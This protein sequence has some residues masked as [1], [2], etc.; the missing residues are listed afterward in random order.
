MRLLRW[1]VVVVSL[2]AVL[3][4]S[5]AT[6]Y[7]ND[8]STNGDIYCST[9]GVDAVGRG[10]NAATPAFSL[11]YLFGTYDIE[12]GET[13][14]IDTG[15][16][17]NYY[18]T[19]TSADGGSG[20]TY[21]DFRG[22]TNRTIGTVMVP[23]SGSPSVITLQDADYCRFADMT[24]QGGLYGVELTSGSDFNEF[25]RVRFLYNVYGV[26]GVSGSGN[27]FENCMA[28]F[29]SGAGVDG[30]GPGGTAG[31]GNLWKNGVSYGNTYGFY[32]NGLSV[33][34]SVIV[35]GVAFGVQ[36]R[37]DYNVFWDTLL[38]PE[39]LVLSELQAATA[40]FGHSTVAD[41][42]FAN[43]TGLDF[44][45]WSRTGR[46][47]PSSGTYVITDTNYSPVIDIGYPSSIYTNEPSPFNGARVN[48]GLYGNTR[49]AS[50]SRTNTWLQVLSYN[51][52]D[53]FLVTGRLWW[54]YG[55]TSSTVSVKLE[56]AYE[57]NLS[58]WLSIVTN[59]PITNQ[60]YQWT[61]HVI[62]G[63]GRW[64]VVLNAD[65]NVRDMS[66]AP[67]S[68]KTSVTHRLVFYVNDTS[69]VN[70]AYCGSIGSFTNHGLTR[71]QPLP[72]LQAVLDAYHISPNDL[73][74][75]DTGTYRL[76][77]AITPS[78]SDQGLPGCPVT[79]RGSTN[80]VA[81]GSI[82]SPTNSSNMR[83]LTV[84][85]VDYWRMENVVLQNA[86]YGVALLN[87]ANSNE[88]IGVWFKDNY[89]GVRG[90]SGYGNHFEN[91]V[92]INN[93]FG[94]VDGFGPGGT[95]GSGNTWK[96]GVSYGNTYAFYVTGM[97]I[98]NSVMV[99]GT[100]FGVSAPGDYNLLWNTTP[101]PGYNNI[102]ALQKDVGSQAH[103]TVADPQFADA[104]NL[105]FH[106]RS[107]AGR[108]DPS[109]GTFVTTD[110][111][112]SPAVD[113]GDPMASYANELPPD[114]A[115][116]NA[117]AF[118][119]T[120]EASKGRT[121]A[122]LQVLN[123]VDGGT[124]NVP[125]D[126]VYWNAGQMAASTTVRIEYS[127]DGG[128]NWDIVATNI[129]ASQGS[130]VWTNTSYG[131]TRSARWRVVCETNTMLF[132]STTQTNFIL[133]N[134]P[135]LYYVNDSS[136]DGDIYCSG[137]GNDFN[138]GTSS[139]GP[140]A[141]LKAL[142]SAHEVQPGDIIYMD[143]GIYYYNE[144]QPIGVLDQGD[145]NSP[146]II[147]GSTNVVAGGTVI[148][149]QN[150]GVGLDITASYLEV[151]DISVTNANIGVQVNNGVSN[152][153]VRVRAERNSTGFLLQNSVGTVFER[154]VAAVNSGD[155]LSLVDSDVSVTHSILWKN[156]GAGI[157]ASG[158]RA[159]ITNSIVVVSGNTAYG[160]HATTSTNIV[161]NHN[162]LYAE[163]HGVVGFIASVGRNQDSLAAWT[164]DTG[165]ER[166]SLSVDPL[167][168]DPENGDFHLKTETS[169]GRYQPGVGWVLDAVTSVLIDS[170]DPQSSWT[171]EPSYN[172]RRVNIGLF[173]NTEE[174][175][176]GRSAGWLHAASLEG[177][178]WVKGTATLHW[179]AGGGATSHAVRV[180]YSPDG[181]ATW[182]VLTNSIAA[183]LESFS[184]DTTK[185]N[186]TPAGL[187]KV[188]STN[189]AGVFDQ[190]TNFFSVR[191][192][193]LVLYVN[194]GSVV[195]DAFSAGVG[196]VA[197]WVASSNRPLNSLQTALT[198][199]DLEPGD[200]IYVDTGAYTNS[201]VSTVSRRDSGSSNAAVQII[202]STNRPGTGTILYAG[203][204]NA[205]Y[206]GLTA[207]YANWLAISNLTLRG[208]FGGM[209]LDNANNLSMGHIW[210][211]ANT[212][213][214]VEMLNV[215]N[216][217]LARCV[218]TG[219][220]GRGMFIQGAAG[221][222]VVHSVIWSN[223]SDAIYHSGGSLAVTNSILHASGVGRYILVGVSNALVRSDY[224]DMVAGNSAYV[225][226]DGGVISKTLSRWQERTSNDVHSLS[227]DPRFSSPLSD[228]HL[229]SLA[230]RYNPATG[231]FVATDTDF[232]YLL[233]AG[234]PTW[235]IGSESGANGGRVNIG[236]F[237]GSAEASRS[238]AA[239]WFVALTY[240]DGGIARGTNN[241]RWVVGGSATDDLVYVDYS[242]DGGATWS[243]VATNV[244]AN[245]GFI[246]WDTTAY[247]SSTRG[248]WR[249]TSQSDGSIV[250]QTDAL[251]SLN[252]EPLAY[253]VNDASTNG[254]VYCSRAGSSTN[255]GLSED[256][257]IDSV[258]AVL[259]RYDL[260]PG[261]R[262]LVDTGV[263][264]LTNAITVGNSIQG[265]FTNRIAIQ[266]STNMTDGGSVLDG[267]S[268]LA[269]GIYANGAGNVEFRHLQ[270]RHAGVGLKLVNVTNCW[271]EWVNTI[272]GAVGFEAEVS[273]NIYFTH[274]SARYA[275]TSGLYVASS[276]NV[277]WG[278]GVFWSNVYGVSMAHLA[279]LQGASVGELFVSNTIVGAFGAGRYAYRVDSGSLRADYNNLF[280]RGGAHVGLRSAYPYSLVHSDLSSWTLA[281]TQ[282]V[283]SLSHDPRFQDP[284]AGD[285]HLRSTAG[286]FDPAVRDFVTNNTDS[287]VLIDA[288]DPQAVISREPVPHGGRINIGL[289]GDSVE[290][291]KTPTN[292]MLAVVIP[293]DGGVVRG[294]NYSVKWFARGGATGHTVRLR[295]SPDEGVSWQTLVT[296]L[297][298]TNLQ[299]T[300]N[301]T[302]S[303]SSLFG[304]L[305]IQSEMD[306][307]VQDDSDVYFMLRNTNFNFYV[308]D[309]N[310][311]GDVYSDG[312]GIATNT[313]LRRENP[314]DSVQGI[315][316]TWDL[317]A[318]DVVYVDTGIYTGSLGR[319]EIGQ[320]DGG[321]VATS[322]TVVIYG[323]TN[324][325]H[326]GSVLDAAG[327]GYGLQL[328]QVSAVELRNLKVQNV[329]T[330]AVQFTEAYGCVAEWLS[331]SNVPTAF[332]LRLSD[333]TRF[334]HCTV[335][336]ASA[337]GL[338]NISASNTLWDSGVLWS[339]RIGVSLVS[340]GAYQTVVG[341]VFVSNSVIASF[342]S[343]S[344]VYSLGGGTL[345]ADYN[346]LY[347]SGGAYV[348]ERVA[349]PFSLI[350]DSV[351]RWSRA[352]KQ[353]MHGLSHEPGFVN[354]GAGDFHPLSTTGRYS[355][356]AGTHVST[357]AVS[358]LLI[359]AGAP[360]AVFG[361]EPVPNGSRR[362][363]GLYGNT[364]EASMSPT[365]SRLTVL[366]LNDGGIADGT[367]FILRW[368]ASGLATGHTVQVKYSPDAGVTW[369][370]LA[371][372]LASD[373]SYPWNTL[374]QTS[375]L[376]G[377]WMVVS[378][379]ETNV[380][381]RNDVFFAVR[382]NPISFYVNDASRSGD[383]YCASIGNSTNSGL[384]PEQP[385]E[386]VQAVL[387][388][389]DLEPEDILYVDTGVY[390]TF[391]DIV[392]NQFDAGDSNTEYVV[393]QGS[394]N[395]ME[396]G[397]VI[398]RRGGAAA[399]VISQAHRI[400]LRNLTIRNALAGV[401][402]SKSLDPCVEWVTVEGGNTGFGLSD[403]RGARFNHCLV[404]DA[405]SGLHS[406]SADVV[407]ENGILWS[408]TYGIYVSAGDVTLQDSVI[409]AYGTNSYALYRG[410]SASIASDYN[411]LFLQEGARAAYSPGV[412]FALVYHN[413][414]RW[415]RDSG[416]DRHSMNCDPLFADAAAGDFH[417]QSSTG[418]Y[419]VSSG[420][421]TNDLVTSPL[422]DAGTPAPAVFTNETSPNGG[423]RNIGLY[424]NSPQAS[425]TPT[426][427]VLRTLSLD[428]GGRAEGTFALNWLARGAV[429]SDTVRL[430]YSPDAG[431]TWLV[432]VTNVDAD[433]GFYVWDARS[434]PSSVRG[435]WS[436][437]AEGETNIY[438]QTDSLFALRNSPLSF[439]VNDGATGGD[440]YSVGSGSH[441][442]SGAVSNQ[443]LDSVVTLLRNWDLEPG[444]SVYIDT[445]NYLLTEDIVVD[446]FDAW[447]ST[448]TLLLRSSPETNRVMFVGSTNE[449]LGGTVFVKFGG[450]YVF[451]IYEAPGVALRN[452]TIRGADIGVNVYYSEQCRADWVRAENC[453]RGFDVSL[454]DSMVMEHCVAR[455]CADRGLSV[456][457]SRDV[458]WLSG[459]LWSNRIGVHQEALANSSHDLTVKNS[460]L[461]SFG[462]NAT[463][464]FIVSG[465][466]VSDYNDI[467]LSEGA[468]AGA[469]MENQGA[470]G[471]TNRYES[472]HFWAKASGQDTHTLSMDPGFANAPAGDFHPRTTRPGGRYDPILEVWTNDADFSRLI[473]AGDPDAAWTNEPDPNGHRIDIGLYGNSTE[474]SKMPTNSW[475]TVITLD[476]GGS[477]KGEQCLY[478]VA[479][480]SLTG[481]YVY[482]N[483]A[484]VSGVDIWTNI[485]TNVAASLGYYCWDT[486][487]Y[488]R[489]AA[490]VW[491]IASTTDSSISDTSSVPFVMR[492]NSGSIW[493][494]VNDAY[495]NGNVYTTVPGNSALA[496]TTPYWPKASVQDI[497]NTYKL[498]PVDIIFVDTGEYLMD[499]EL[500]IGDLDSG[501]GTNRVTI[502]GSTNFGA[503]GTILNR[504]VAQAG[505]YGVFLDRAAGIN[506]RH[507][508]VRNAG[509]GVYAEDADD[510]RIENVRSEGNAVAG[511]SVKRS[512]GMDFQNCTAWNNGTTGGVG[513]VNEESSL[514]W[515]NGVVA[516]NASAVTMKK[517]GT[518]QI[519]NSFLSAVGAGNRIYTIDPDTALAA[520]QSGYNDLLVSD[521][522]LVAERRRGV[523]G[524]ENYPTLY[525]WQVGASQ[526]IHSLSHEPL[527]A[528]EINGD[529]HPTSRKGRFLA[530]GSMT[531]DMTNS[532]LLD[533]GDPLGVYT[534]E[535]APN[536]SNVNIGCYGNTPYA[537]LSETNPWLLA[538]SF[539][540]R[541]TI[542]GTNTVRWL[543]GGMTNTS[544]VYLEYSRDGG[545]QWNTIVSNLLVSSDG[546]SWDVS[547]ELVTLH[548]LWRVTS[549]SYAGIVDEVDEEFIIKNQALTIYVNDTNTIGDMYCSAPGSAAN[550]GLTNSAPLDDPATAFQLY[551]ITAED[552][553]YIDTGYYE[554]TNSMVLGEVNRGLS[555]GIIRILGSTNSVRGGSL[556]DGGGYVA[557]GLQ[558]MDTRYVKVSHLRFTGFD[559]GVRVNNSLHCDFSWIEAFANRSDG[560]AVQTLVDGLFS[561]SSSW[562]NGGWGLSIGGSGLIAEWAN[563]VLWNNQ[564]GGIDLGNG[565]LGLY[566]SVVVSTISNSHLY[567]ISQGSLSADF[568]V[569]WRTNGAILA[570]DEYR[571]VIYR[572]LQDWQRNVGVDE[573]SVMVDPLFANAAQGDFHLRS[574]RGRWA[575]NTW[576]VDTNTSWAIDAGRIGD[577]Y[578]HEPPPN[579]YRVNVG[580]YGNTNEASLS[581][582]S[583]AARAL[584]AVSLDDGG[585]VSGAKKL[586]WLSRGFTSD[587]RVRV[588]FSEDNGAS[589]VVLASNL[590]ATQNGYDWTP[591]AF[592]STPIA[593]WRVVY[594]DQT[595]IADTIGS[596]FILR[597]GPITFYVNDASIS[598]DIYCS[599]VG[600]PA[601]SG[602]ASNIPKTE[603]QEILDY[604]LE[605]GDVVLVDTGFYP[606]TNELFIGSVL[607]G[608]STARVSIIGSTNWVWGASVFQG[609]H[610]AFVGSVGFH[611][612]SAQYMLVRN[613][614]LQN[615]D[616]GVFFELSGSDNVISNIVVRDGGSAGVRFSQS[617]GNR[618]AHSVITRHTGHGVV[619]ASASDNIF[620]SCVLWDNGL[621]S[622][623]LGEGSMAFTNSVLYASGDENFCYQLVTN[624]N[625]RGDFNNLF[626]TNGA[627]IG[628]ARGVPMERLPQWIAATTQDVHSLSVDPLFHDP[629]NDDF[630]LQ[631][632]FGRF[633]PSVGVFVTNDTATSYLVDTGP[634]NYPY[635]NEP[636]LNGNRVNIG[637]HGNTSEASQSRTNQWLL[638][639]TA[640]SGGR[641]EGIFYLVW[642]W[643]GMDATNLITIDYFN[644][645]AWTNI[646]TS[647]IHRIQYLWQSD[648]K[649]VGAEKW[650][651]SPIGRWR[652]SI[653]GNTNVYDMTDLT[654][655][656]RNRPF[657]YFVNDGST[658]DDI[659]ASEIGSDTNLGIFAYVPKATL[660]SL[661][662]DNDIEGE[663]TIYI[664]T[665]NYVIGD[666]DVAVM[667]NADQGRVGAPVYMRGN[668][669]AMVSVFNRTV[670]GGGPTTILTINGGYID[671]SD[672]VF[673]GGHL[674]AAGPSLTLSDLLFR[675]GNLAL[676]GANQFVTDVRISTGTLSVA[677][678]PVTVRRATVQAGQVSLAGTNALL[679]S[680]LV[681]G[682]AGPAVQIAGSDITVRNNTLATGGDQVRKAG[683]G[684]ATLENNII[685]ADGLENFCIRLDA[686]TL[687]S[688]YNNLIARNGAWIGNRNGNWERL[689]YWQRESGNDLHSLSHDPL[690]A[691]ETNGDF[692]LK[693]VAGR[694]D[695]VNWTN[696]TEHSP[697]IDAG[698]PSTVATNEPL[699][700]GF[701]VNLGAYGGT[702]EAS[703]SLTNAWLLA[704]TIN[705]GGVLRGTNML[706][707]VAGNLDSNDLVRL[708]YSLDY[709][710]NWT[711]IASDQPAASQEYPW[712]SPV[713][714]SSFYSL[715]KV[716][717]QTNTLVEDQTDVPFALRN[718][719]LRFYVNDASS[720]ND[721]YCSAVG[722]AGNLGTASNVP[723]DTLQGILDAYDTEG[724]DTIF[725]DTGT[726]AL[727][728]DVR[729]I[730]S[731]GGDDVYGN[732]LIRGSTN[733]S[734]GGSIISRGSLTS[735]NDAFDVKA[736][737]V[738]L[739]DFTVRQAYRGVYFDSNRFCLAERLLVQSNTYGIVNQN[740]ISITNRNIRFWRNAA[741]GMD[742]IGARTTL[743]ENATFVG[744]TGF[745]LR[746]Q[747]SA[748]NTLQNNIFYITD[749]GSPA[750]A[751]DSNTI[752]AA[753]IDYNVYHFA[754]TSAIYGTYRDLRSWQLN[755]E[756]DY[757]SAI[758]NPLFANV[759]SG[760]FHLQ[761]TAGRFV[762]NSGWVNDGANSWAI[763][764]GNPLSSYSLEP[765]TNGNRINVGAYGGTEFASKGT[766]NFVV[767]ARVLNDPTSIG[768]TNSFW[769]LIWT[770]Q[771]IP[772]GITFRVQYSG[773]GGTNWV[774]LATNVDA[775]TEY[776]LWQTE[777]YYNT[778]KGRWRVVSDS[779]TNYWDMNDA[780]F[781]IFYG[782]FKI[783]SIYRNE[784]LRDIVWRGAWD[785]FYQVQYATNLLL[786]EEQAWM[787][788]PT[789]A[790]PNQV[791]YF[792]ST[793]GGDFTYEDVESFG[794]PH[795]FYRVVRLS[796]GYQSADVDILSQTR[797]RGMINVVW[798][799]TSPGT[800]TVQYST[801]ANQW[802]T[803]DTGV[804]TNQQATFYSGL[805]GNFSF[806]DI[807]SSNASRRWYRV[808]WSP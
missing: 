349:E 727:P 787:N 764:K 697:C 473:D 791:P 39:G 159:T 222:Q 254:D 161:G 112:T 293:N 130:Y 376:Q 212:S 551:P 751:G 698:A 733:A 634:T 448:N 374:V 658:N 610:T 221:V 762:D 185:T 277:Q 625:I 33:T 673:D 470:T 648:L 458:G 156:G 786:S 10:T 569:L 34:N 580:L 618:I 385:K 688:D 398:D 228:L 62:S 357:D 506:L 377:V 633:D 626:I 426:N 206:Y 596:T 570:R 715:W 323:S 777:P 145:T 193:N 760:D 716:E 631:S 803:A 187:W 267:Q 623:Y 235:S 21:V 251:F 780:I 779:N 593:L 163:S 798:S 342:G 656:L 32:V 52:N 78:L 178:G 539:N 683:S 788:A 493:Y 140:K 8:G 260:L 574:E 14:W 714:T 339:N 445:G 496:G 652:L 105:D 49:E 300:W 504:Q 562:G 622:V 276:T 66:D 423:R 665:G 329:A 279:T 247:R 659:Y 635:G 564:R 451:N 24:F 498:E 621:S 592:P 289:Y 663:D 807:A 519:G 653:V 474:A 214:G 613:F 667:G 354:P 457:L 144:D 283:H 547:G 501:S 485:A 89:V 582:T 742:V 559:T 418:R 31:S 44:H 240:N 253:Y 183:N 100:A 395:E 23:Q 639:I 447:D 713:G 611:F 801:N 738:T 324:Y 587:D 12:P 543:H 393:V 353:D 224:N 262:V 54:T 227:H 108:Y 111:N 500:R 213:N 531:N 586:Y 548:A 678:A 655:S 208:G 397:S 259:I 125:T 523:G 700:N 164:M 550:S 651:S 308:N 249:I 654:F 165:W 644:G 650:P 754:Q 553:V 194:D 565:S 316:D 763:D 315:L 291:S 333:N 55:E 189:D 544:R 207:S 739:R 746:V 680:S 409:T 266:G 802:A 98:S 118:G 723:K 407:W 628:I 642:A 190:T 328:Q 561:H 46:Y 694:W 452:L 441:T 705:D 73:I 581:V 487:N 378:E 234:D 412:P 509:V 147:Q 695:G 127:P 153:F 59:V 431:K 335:L 82:L 137:P 42:Q 150:T 252:N 527:F 166:N 443:P 403:A 725:V 405:T 141:A 58:T 26:R 102:A 67:I 806:E 410:S 619:G 352:T 340:E 152:R 63:V 48:A 113:F 708:Q 794:G 16:Y 750:I 174:A 597:N 411:D 122:W 244:S 463:A 438:D 53:S 311:V 135:Y 455:G 522:A 245:L 219:N 541:T 735:D 499:A 85:G 285:F 419:V 722:A 162:D 609:A 381:D 555:N 736:S 170:G 601:N 270:L 730:W 557:Y 41:P 363:I 334:R 175:S 624:A 552:T 525:D 209:R 47:D 645:V 191:N 679:E 629:A 338:R 747:G 92:A 516:D 30:F 706:R 573:S 702:P 380:H 450:G 110:T 666:L 70:D 320:L 792:K 327:S 749:A 660:K 296:G 691:N 181:G 146:V 661:L 459:I 71:G 348:V 192:T 114:G 199:F 781:N 76:T 492:D 467:F 43:A 598:G 172:G 225:A 729:V 129:L 356:T 690:F 416:N 524:S 294:T 778:Y 724:G 495:T 56:Y 273:P 57:T 309:T 677:G 94:G 246:E 5:G 236:L 257:P 591:T 321:S 35:G 421:F 126:P 84:D 297:A 533:A 96:N 86:F 681:Y 429:T 303:T 123:Y 600:D 641:Y 636:P 138:L 360:S 468:L 383:V 535:L 69:T 425:Q 204:T 576:V 359:D 390:T 282:D 83:V 632:E 497:L 203:N 202:G 99:G 343:N 420:A 768:E 484:P 769:P 258:Q 528:D 233:D 317:E 169:Q 782:E 326:G 540:A 65:N 686:G 579:G 115:R 446:R 330:T 502:V 408:N 313:G 620:D 80:M 427:S 396:G 462:S 88:F 154:C 776:I 336:G 18:L 696:D 692:H 718:S 530:D 117:G 13:V 669:N 211:M 4:A 710:T 237:G 703:M 757:R 77:N 517:A 304:L 179:V 752:A 116:L 682:G 171:N 231:T 765:A 577:D 382:N 560:I 157:R 536:G 301:T 155:G 549:E 151:R 568:N 743:V 558:M 394:T 75:V 210:A 318:G 476:D 444:D 1:C 486:T 389:W 753:F 417:L 515:N 307:G 7:V 11:A 242:A 3:H 770:V 612:K 167:F 292:A 256:R 358:S 556:L 143:T 800:F 27:L 93:G 134:G 537:S 538:V 391:T 437:R 720:A 345:R 95:V 449:S 719:L 748:N 302:I 355:R 201:G 119:N 676:N 790:A 261:D 477:V 226:S 712:E 526:D 464:N 406:D 413:V 198:I 704:T 789:G 197:N 306:A 637:V 415:T 200:R 124:L 186:D 595:N 490:G 272:G 109:L 614:T 384:V 469:I 45:P 366:T 269:H 121:N 325:G 120:D 783:T 139:N 701:R 430:D 255:N 286:R 149:R 36:A 182:S 372:G 232:S 25:L 479:G 128:A 671:M 657:T 2:G 439:Y 351:S 588:E 370:T 532:P 643:G 512:I 17:T 774:D 101:A 518:T 510:C 759:E 104:G 583:A 278:S 566:N 422:I 689:F 148:R 424:G 435:V 404:R 546:Y 177:G 103:S 229:R 615:V 542:R 50:K 290:A 507:L 373:A 344:F 630:H 771:N 399:F 173:G 513:I 585:M 369:Q 572:K 19:L 674:S 471:R 731:R 505:T 602:L 699:P 563:G 337:Y 392:F 331:V 274:C 51:G 693:S 766:T 482:L 176:K 494:F 136:T 453:G 617:S 489:S 799:C 758:T 796:A 263:Y 772:G 775:Y 20:G 284:G 131:S 647:E 280:A 571:S 400:K 616:N 488:G 9:S 785:E 243:N 466:R 74:Y 248:V 483:F 734:A 670:W 668:T 638:A 347:A 740:T 808:K 726:Y 158:G 364:T 604:D 72:G 475:L 271:V 721:I 672:V 365:N 664:D 428:D 305:R 717:L 627:Q 388:A 756:H 599:A 432:I 511:F 180:E 606:L 554:V 520:L 795:R 793:F 361:S 107:Q 575:T 367:N 491:R 341:T 402:V 168:A 797:S 264:F 79:I 241:I 346:D 90:L 603:L 646:G 590:V 745:S 223:A 91:C 454:S 217:H 414:S 741:G 29:S 220:G 281:S 685:I 755:E 737:H 230:G 312:A 684:N 28:F 433:T 578:T 299:Y 322:T 503:G 709:G 350:Y 238:P 15:T 773:D 22:S 386:S 744:N 188:T 589:W 728:A 133:R 97:S 64:R 61:N 268:N 319:F 514:A 508:T 456:H 216:A 87:A 480:G 265:E 805:S 68:W 472:V 218:L 287:S 332:A 521:S 37:G 675:S 478:W 605:G 649:E 481:G 401:E 314:K 375:A 640:S 607:S 184:W 594:Q 465:V 239:G 442:N 545:V 60:Y 761:S 662:E 160:Y 387:N 534:N 804:A 362:N 205:G 295:Y 6:Y 379:N 40:D 784:G 707:W 250:D 38:T 567:R 215:N 310:P 81:G 298:A 461:G 371:T 608:V 275:Q 436:I 711:T 732:L 687:N 195:G 584:F 106:L 288:G 434:Y 132:S 767:Y 142:L 196:S 440:V 368:L 529:F 460:V